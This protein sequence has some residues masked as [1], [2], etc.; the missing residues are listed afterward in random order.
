MVVDDDPAMRLTLGV[1]IEEEGYDVVE[2][3]DGYQAVELAKDNDL[4]LIFMDIVMPGM[5]GEGSWNTVF[6]HHSYLL[7]STQ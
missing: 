2:A 4:G 7:Q 6:E 1:I 5:H 3:S